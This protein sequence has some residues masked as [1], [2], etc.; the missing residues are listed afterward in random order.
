MKYFDIVY[1]KP[2]QSNTKMT[3]QEQRI[4][5]RIRVQIK[6]C[7]YETIPAEEPECSICYCS[8]NRENIVI[9]NCNHIYCVSCFKQYMITK[10]ND[11]TRDINCPMCRQPVSRI[12]LSASNKDKFQQI[13]F[14]HNRNT[15]IPDIPDFMEQPLRYEPYEPYEPINNQLTEQIRETNTNTDIRMNDI[16]LFIYDSSIV[17]TKILLFIIGISIIIWMIWMIHQNVTIQITFKM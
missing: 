4:R 5:I 6:K 11:N 9:T 2:N 8:L 17:I 14:I 7:E 10:S 12:S 13:K 15:D 3:T 1:N 16:L